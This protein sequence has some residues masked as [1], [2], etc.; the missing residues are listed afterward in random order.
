MR[1]PAPACAQRAAGFGELAEQFRADGQPVAASQRLD[2]AN[3]AEA[4]AHHHRLVAVRLV[5]VVDAADRLHARIFRALIVAAFMLLVPVV[6]AAD[7]GEIR[8]TPA[9]AQA[10]AWVKENSR[11]RLV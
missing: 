2:L 5:V 4:R 7:K 1:G 3:V 9:S 11:V 10:T 8:N 6:D